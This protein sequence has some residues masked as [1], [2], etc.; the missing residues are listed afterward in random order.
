M[1]Q[2]SLIILHLNYFQ[3]RFLSFNK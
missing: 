2:L 1:F 3:V